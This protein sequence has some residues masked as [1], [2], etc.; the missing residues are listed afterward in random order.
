M[1]D[2]RVREATRQRV[3]E[4]LNNLRYAP[5]STPLGRLYVAYRG[6]AVCYA[7]VAV[8]DRAFERACAR[9]LGLLPVRENHLQNGLAK[10]I[11]DHVNGKRPF[12]GPFDLSGV[13]PFQRLVLKKVRRIR[14]GEVRSY[15]WVAEQIGAR[16]AVRAVGTALARNPIPFLIPCHRVVKSD[17]R[18][19]NYS[20]GGPSMKARVLA[21]EGVGIEGLERPRRPGIR[22]AGRA[23]G[24]IF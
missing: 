2:L 4:G 8:S 20:A 1:C 14:H 5:I 12:S 6:R 10:Q 15:R 18:I 17:G 22:L 24:K 23:A 3:G 7:M 9:D 13:T 19:G 11:V 16:R 21:F